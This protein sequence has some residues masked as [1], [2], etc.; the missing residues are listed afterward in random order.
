MK[1]ALIE[2]LMELLKEERDKRRKEMEGN[3]ETMRALSQKL[4]RLET[5]L[6]LNQ[7]MYRRVGRIECDGVD[8][9]DC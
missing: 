7:S 1:D 2:L 9:V 5:N 6:I 3:A 8:E 4:E